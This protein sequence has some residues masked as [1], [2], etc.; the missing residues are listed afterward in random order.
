MGTYDEWS[1][2]A[3]F[4]ALMTVSA[5]SLELIIELLGV[6]NN[7]RESLVYLR[8]A[9]LL[10]LIF[11]MINEFGSRLLH[12]TL[13]FIVFGIVLTIAASAVVNRRFSRAA[14]AS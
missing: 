12:G 4:V 2:V 13:V 11:S 6:K 5:T 10:S 9:I 14:K 8:N 3:R 1:H 7:P